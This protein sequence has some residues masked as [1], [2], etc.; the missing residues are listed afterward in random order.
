MDDPTVDDAVADPDDLP[1]EAD[2]ADV[3]EQ[4]LIVP[5]V[6]DEP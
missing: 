5:E 6:I 1:L 3:S 2:P 4:R